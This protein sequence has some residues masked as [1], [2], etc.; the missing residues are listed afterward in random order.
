[1]KSVGRPAACRD[2]DHDMKREL[3]NFR[4]DGA[5]IV[6]VLLVGDS[7]SK[8][9]YVADIAGV[10]TQCVKWKNVQRPPSGYFGNLMLKINTKLGGTNHTLISRLGNNANDSRVFQK[11]PASISW[12][13]DRP[14]M[15]VGMDVSHPEVN[16][17]GASVAA[18]VSINNITIN[19]LYFNTCLIIFF[20]CQLFRYTLLFVINY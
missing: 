20:A 19:S 14:C 13:F 6:V 2:S 7:Y 15:L 12:V 5:K 9:K 11:P 17:E 16:R 4:Q 3:A 8:V 1:M 10:V 18:V